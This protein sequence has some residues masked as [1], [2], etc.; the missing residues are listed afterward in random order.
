MSESNI[1]STVLPAIRQNQ[2]FYAKPLPC[3][4]VCGIFKREAGYTCYHAALIGCSSWLPV[5]VACNSCCT[6]SI[7]L[8]RLARC[9]AV[10]NILPF[11]NML[12]IDLNV[13]HVQAPPA[14]GRKSRKPPADKSFE[15]FFSCTSAKRF[16]AVTH[17]YICMS[18]ARS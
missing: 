14:R 12:K 15:F 18:T 13:D 8:F 16:Y 5:V 7:D 2:R 3:L 4:T 11:D 9:V 17:C 1:S 10:T 6:P